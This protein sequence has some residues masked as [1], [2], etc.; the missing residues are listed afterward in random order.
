MSIVSAGTIED[1]NFEVSSPSQSLVSSNHTSEGSLITSEN[2]LLHIFRL[3]TIDG[4]H[5]SNDGAV[6]L[7]SSNDNGASW[8][9]AQILVSGDFDYRNARSEVIGDKIITFFR[10]FDA[11]T[12]QPLALQYI[13]GDKYGANWTEPRDLPFIDLNNDFYEMWIDN[14]QEVDGGMLFTVHAVGYFQIWKAELTESSE[15]SNARL[16]Y[17]LD[18][19]NLNDPQKDFSGID[20]PELLQFADGRILVLFRNDNYAIYSRSLFAMTSTDGGITF[21]PIVDTGLCAPGN[22]KSIA[23][24]LIKLG[25]NEF[26][27]IGSSRDP[28]FAE[29][30]GPIYLGNDQLCMVP[31]SVSNDGELSFGNVSYFERALK[32]RHG[33]LARLYGYP[34]S[35]PLDEDSWLVIYTDAMQGIELDKEQ[36]HIFQFSLEKTEDQ[37]D[38]Y[39]GEDFLLGSLRLNTVSDAVVSVNYNDTV[40]IENVVSGKALPIPFSTM[41]LELSWRDNISD[42]IRD[43]WLEYA[44]NNL[45]SFILE[46]A[47]ISD[48]VPSYVYDFNIDG[49]LSAGDVLE[50]KRIQAKL[51]LQSMVIPL[52]KESSPLVLSQYGSPDKDVRSQAISDIAFAGDVNHE[53]ELLESDTCPFFFGQ[54]ILVV[55]SD[56]PVYLS[57]L[58]SRNVD[59]GN[60]R[61]LNLLDNELISIDVQGDRLVSDEPIAPYSISTVDMIFESQTCYVSRKYIVVSARS[62]IDGDLILNNDDDDMDGD[63]FLNSVD[64]LFWDSRSWSD[65][66]RDGIGDQIDNDLDN[67]GITNDE[68]SDDDG[69]DVKDVLDLNPRHKEI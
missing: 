57:A 24:H 50:L 69:D 53:F 59:I 22:S 43:K 29:N 49:S 10:V 36:A 61:A 27:L 31:G 4:N 33:P 40:N 13:V 9:R 1:I 5:V 64:A 52:D 34:V 2:R 26:L 42:D 56:A 30:E 66:D 38:A 6:A 37:S 65:L 41:A 32:G 8:S 15:L 63:G 47:P 25:D 3:T 20:E 58:M 54:N 60:I 67:D 28:F 35:T 45:Q 62:D 11:H 17:T 39:I 51:G 55:S 23:P 68:D 44:F 16:V 18:K 7:R 12:Y 46:G 19:R 14:P 48:S 21:S